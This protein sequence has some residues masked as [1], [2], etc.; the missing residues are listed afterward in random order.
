DNVIVVNAD[1]VALTGNKVK[2]KIYY[3][4]SSYIGN[5]RAKRAEEVL[6]KNP[7]RVI[8]EA[9]KGM[10]PKNKIG[11]KLFL[12]LKV[13]AGAEHPHAAQNPQPMGERTATG[14]K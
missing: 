11:K 1:K 10:L 9:V 6:A 7:E 8:E 3:R 14:D 2:E 4:H 12:N 5:L 13:Y